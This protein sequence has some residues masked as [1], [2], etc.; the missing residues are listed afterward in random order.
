MNIFKSKAYRFANDPVELPIGRA[1]FDQWATEVLSLTRLPD[2]DSTRFALA[3]TIPHQ[4]ISKGKL[5]RSYFAGL[6]MKSAAN[7]VA[8]SVMEDL[9]AKQQAAI[10]AANQVEVPTPPAPDVKPIQN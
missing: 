6:L 4:E 3:S 7:Q 9:K 10:D 1:E 5:P 2:N 8:F